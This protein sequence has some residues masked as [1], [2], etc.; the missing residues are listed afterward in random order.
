MR[1]QGPPR[2]ALQ[3]PEQCSVDFGLGISAGG[4]CAYRSLIVVLP[5]SWKCHGACRSGASDKM[6]KMLDYHGI[7]VHSGIVEDPVIQADSG[8]SAARLRGAHLD[9]K[10]TK[11][12]S[13]SFE[14]C[15]WHQ[16][17]SKHSNP[18]MLHHTNGS[19]S[20]ATKAIS[21]VHQTVEDLIRGWFVGQSVTYR[22]EIA[23]GRADTHSREEQAP[24]IEET[25]LSNASVKATENSL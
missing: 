25:R 10:S 15:S 1:R 24:E 4:L 23:Q 3:V 17:L 9:V 14:F 18:V 22:A 8:I 11:V 12:S 13:T 2:S 6:L 21:K 16:C 19:L 20:T 7:V 5:I